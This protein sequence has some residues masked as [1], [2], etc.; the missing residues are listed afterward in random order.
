MMVVVMPMKPY[1]ALVYDG[2]DGGV[3]KPRWFSNRTSY[4]WLMEV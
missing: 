3:F 4:A 1:G 2:G